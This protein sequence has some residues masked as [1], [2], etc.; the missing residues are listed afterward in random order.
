VLIDYPADRTVVAS[1][2]QV[3]LPA[4]ADDGGSGSRRRAR[5][6]QDHPV[7]GF[8][9]EIGDLAITRHDVGHV[10]LTLALHPDYPGWVREQVFQAASAALTYFETVFGPY[11]L[12]YLTIVSAP[13]NY[14]QGLL[15]L[16][17]LSVGVLNESDQ[18]FSALLNKPD[19]RTV[20]AHEIAHQWWGHLV[21][22][23]GYRDQW[24]SEATANYAALRFTREVLQGD[25][26][27]GR[28]ITAGWR[29]HLSAPTASGRTIEA[30]G[31]IA[32]GQR[33]DSS[34]SDD[35]YSI[36]VY[37]KG[38]VVLDMLAQILGEDRFL[39]MLGQM[40][41]HAAGRLLS[42]E[43]FLAALAHMSGESLDE[44]ARQYVYGTGMSEVDYRFAF[45][46]EAGGVWAVKGEARQRPTY[47]FRYGVRR[48]PSGSWDIER[49]RVD[50]LSVEDSR[51]TVP[52]GV[53]VRMEPERQ[54]MLGATVRIAGA[55]STFELRT[56][57]R[58]LDLVVD[59]AGRV[60]ANFHSETQRPKRTLLLQGV[61]LV[62]AARFTEAEARLE[63]ALEAPAVPASGPLSDAS[64]IARED[65][66]LDGMIHL[67]RARLFLD[68]DRDGDAADALARGRKSLDEP[69]LEANAELLAILEA[70]LELH[71]GAGRAALKRLREA[72]PEGAE[73]SNTEGITLLAI[74]AHQAGGLEASAR[75]A[76]V[77][78][79]RG[80][81]LSALSAP[82]R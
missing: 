43:E 34:Y 62:A 44:F 70:R 81:D 72:F 64:E 25:V 48:T 42:T 55:Q 71:R 16:V 2:A 65:A 74:A 78:T 19:R 8:T 35:A 79:R 63:Q 51:L 17:S 10:S 22:W 28:E 6:R 9:F 24:L 20:I 73:S 59:P 29:K 4:A 45:E 23:K 54:A 38:A 37:E 60:L 14:S 21:G 30:L 5:F 26:A 39:K 56:R 58:P 36:I 3:E 66:F 40:S 41:R 11:P 46:E 82:V 49:N 68:Q 32:I 52:I 13:R 15:G 53:L 75:V 12:D 50:R 77:A 61:D 7:E 18:M 67:Q 1:G 76:A 80:A 69:N 31:P 57:H 27:T 47:G 33:L